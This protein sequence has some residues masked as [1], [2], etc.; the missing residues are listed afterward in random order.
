MVEGLEPP[1]I[2][3]QGFVILLLFITYCL[4][5]GLKYSFLE[6]TTKFEQMEQLAHTYFLLW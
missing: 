5:Q 6:F 3:L 1:N 2:F 4:F